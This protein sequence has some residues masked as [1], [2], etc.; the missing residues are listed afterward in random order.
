MAEIEK[1]AVE[2]GFGGLLSPEV[3]ETIMWFLRRW[4]LTYLL[5]QVKISYPFSIVYLSSF[6]KFYLIF[7]VSTGKFLFRN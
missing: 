1:R 5:P 4:S 3:S 7:L 6:C 2:A